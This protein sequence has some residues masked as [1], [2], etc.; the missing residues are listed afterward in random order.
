MTNLVNEKKDLDAKNIQLKIEQTKF[1]ENYK[2]S[3]E[4]NTDKLKK[5]MH[6][7][8]IQHPLR[9]EKWEDCPTLKQS[10]NRKILDVVGL[11]DSYI[12]YKRD[13]RLTLD[14][15]EIRSEEYIAKIN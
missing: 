12:K 15:S 9:G 7:Y 4:K 5:I 11:P 2:A 8:D 1:K 13:Q 3:L 14:N 6:R 10:F